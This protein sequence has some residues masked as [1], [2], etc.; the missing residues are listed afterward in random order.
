[1]V[2]LTVGLPWS[3]CFLFSNVST[4][5]FRRLLM[6]LNRSGDFHDQRENIKKE[7]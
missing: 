4:K 7:Y 2:C 6:V 5:T 3:V 1:M